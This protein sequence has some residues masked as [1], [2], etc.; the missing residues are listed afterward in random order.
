MGKA[1]LDRTKIRKRALALLKSAEE[2]I[3]EGAT[4]ATGFD[5]AADFKRA[6]LA[7]LEAYEPFHIAVHEYHGQ[8][9]ENATTGPKAH[10][11]RNKLGT[12][13]AIQKGSGHV[14]AARFDAAGRKKGKRG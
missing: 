10:G 8:H 14:Q 5:D 6:L 7:D 3:L 2:V 13:K 1:A 12:K 9:A 4:R 11:R